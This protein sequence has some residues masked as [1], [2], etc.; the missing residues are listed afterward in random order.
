MKNKDEE[1]KIRQ[2]TIEEIYN[3][4]DSIRGNVFR[5]YRMDSMYSRY[6][7]GDDAKKMWKGEF[8]PTGEHRRVIQCNDAARQNMII[9]P[10]AGKDISKG[11]AISMWVRYTSPYMKTSKNGLL[12]F[13]DPY[14]EH[15]H[16]LYHQSFQ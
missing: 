3:F 4:I 15:I 1:F 16:H 11:C 2:F 10:F 14:Q 9:N 7:D 13:L 5:S 8:K 6:I 12:L